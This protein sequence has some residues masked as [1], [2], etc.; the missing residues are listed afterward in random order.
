LRLNRTWAIKS[1]TQGLCVGG[2]AK[3]HVIDQTPLSEAL[4]T[5]SHVTTDTPEPASLALFG[6]GFVVLGGA[7]RRRWHR[8]P[9]RP[10]PAGNCRAIAQFGLIHSSGRSVEIHFDSSGLLLAPSHE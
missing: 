4:A 5:Q 2:D 7:V 1:V 10:H 8:Y 3:G 6:T 9:L